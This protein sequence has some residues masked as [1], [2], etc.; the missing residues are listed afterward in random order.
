MSYEL[1]NCWSSVTN[2]T[3]EW[4]KNTI[5]QNNEDVAKNIK[6][7]SVD[8]ENKLNLLY[9]IT[10]DFNTNNLISNDKKGSRN[11]I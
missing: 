8:I 10:K 1:P 2:L 4:I 11:I 3:E 9:K 5:G 6:D 7:N